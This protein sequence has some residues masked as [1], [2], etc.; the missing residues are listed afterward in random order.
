[1][2]KIGN[3]LYPLLKTKKDSIDDNIRILLMHHQFKTILP[4]RN[5]DEFIHIAV[6]S[7]LLIL[8]K[9]VFIMIVPTSSNFLHSGHWTSHRDNFWFDNIDLFSFLNNNFLGNLILDTVHSFFLCSHFFYFFPIGRW[10][11]GRSWIRPVLILFL[12]VRNRRLWA[13]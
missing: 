6:L 7:L 3:G 1:M 4:I 2:L 8:G 10:V 12:K 5:H 11:L 9:E 13:A